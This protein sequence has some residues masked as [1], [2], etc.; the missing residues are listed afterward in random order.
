MVSTATAFQTP[1]SANLLATNPIHFEMGALKTTTRVKIEDPQLLLS[2][3]AA[4][5]LAELRFPNLKYSFEAPVV[6]LLAGPTPNS[7]ILKLGIA[8][9]ATLEVVLT[10]D[11]SGIETDV[12]LEN[13]A[14]TARSTF[15]ATTLMLMLALDGELKLQ[16]TPGDFSTHHR[17]STPLSYVGVIFPQRKITYELMVIEQA[18]GTSFP[19]AAPHN[20]VNPALITFIHHAITKKEFVWQFYQEAF[21]LRATETT[22]SFLQD[23]HAPL[24]LQIPVN[25]FVV[26]F[27]GKKIDLGR[28]YVR[29]ENAIITNAEQ[30]AKELEQLDG[31]DFPAFICS[32]NG[33]ATYQFLQT[34]L[35]PSSFDQLT[36]EFIDIGEQLVDLFFEAVN[37]LAAA[38][39]DEETALEQESLLADLSFEFSEDDDSTSAAKE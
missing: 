6:G 27:Q 28:H 22:K 29:I 1:G 26:E 7:R 25:H 18:Y 8:E 39:L 14:P 15:M 38:S 23:M 24:T 37:H 17:V 2:K 20:F 9:E 10:S 21:S 11:Q 5:K 33:A 32:P 36:Q 3:L 13:P 35:P 30:I 4:V 12:I 19:I 16:L 31:H 34:S